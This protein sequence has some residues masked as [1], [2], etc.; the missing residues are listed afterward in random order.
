MLLHSG[1]HHPH[2]ASHSILAQPAGSYQF[3]TD[4]QSRWISDVMPCPVNQ[5]THKPFKDLRSLLAA[6]RGQGLWLG[7]LG[8]DLA[9]W[10]EVLP[11]RAVNDRDWPVIELAFCPHWQ[12]L[13]TGWGDGSM[14]DAQAKAS[15]PLAAHPCPGVGV[16]TSAV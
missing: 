9:R 4:G 16:H 15:Q 12:K 1:R 5:W 10:N 11:S 8:Y 6:T 13:A 3:T 2:W 14:A 7:Y